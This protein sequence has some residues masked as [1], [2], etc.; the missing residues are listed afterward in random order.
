M[1]DTP[2]IVGIAGGSG[3]GKST[4]AFHF[5]D[6]YP[7]QVSIVHIDDYQK[8]VKEVPRLMGMTNWDDP[9]AIDFGLL[10]KHIQLLLNNHPVEVWTKDD[11]DNSQYRATGIRSKTVISSRPLIILEGYL[12]LYHPSVREL[13]SYAVFLDLPHSQRVA[14]CTKLINTDYTNNILMPMHQQYVEPTKIFANLVI[15]VN[16][17]STQQV[18]KLIEDQLISRKLLKVS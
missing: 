7:E 11:R 10:L 13:L 9:D 2:K 3:A 15:K 17:L 18:A 1:I 14:R 5:K 12:S 8:E 16:N 6:L 4:M